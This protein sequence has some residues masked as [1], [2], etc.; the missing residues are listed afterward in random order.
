MLFLLS[1]A[2]LATVL[3]LCRAPWS[4][5][6]PSLPSL[7]MGTERAPLWHK[8]TDPNS[9]VELDKTEF[10]L[11]IATVWVL[12]LAVEIAFRFGNAKALTDHPD[13]S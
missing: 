5:V 10:A 8:P 11:E 1:I 4:R 13:Q 3:L 6:H 9:V 12:V 2:V 7:P